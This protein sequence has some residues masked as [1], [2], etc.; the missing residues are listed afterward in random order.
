VS[1]QSRNYT[2]IVFALISSTILLSVL[3]IITSVNH[4]ERID[5]EYFIYALP[6]IIAISIVPSLIVWVA[7][8]RKWYWSVLVG[9][10]GGFA[11]AVAYIQIAT[12][13]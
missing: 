1:W 7:R 11:C 12:S 5:Y 10:V 6:R 4:Y 3:F 13:I 8:I 9:C 2:Q